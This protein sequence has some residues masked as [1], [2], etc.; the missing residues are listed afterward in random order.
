MTDL[1]PPPP[2]SD[3]EDL[4]ISEH[5]RLMWSPRLTAEDASAFYH[6]CPTVNAC[7]RSQLTQLETI[8][9]LADLLSKYHSELCE[10]KGRYVPFSSSL[11]NKP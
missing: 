6:Y 3:I 8:Y 1:F 10:L 5:H 4:L 2:P 11:S 9:R 7:V